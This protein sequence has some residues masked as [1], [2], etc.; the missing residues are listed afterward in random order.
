M[1]I[2]VVAIACVAI[3]AAFWLWWRRRTRGRRYPIV[4][5]HGLFGFD[6]VEVMGRTHHYFNGVVTALEELGEEVHVV[7]L[8]PVASVA[9]RAN[10]L[11]EFVRGL[12]A[13]R[14]NLI[15]HSM[16]GV[17]ARY[18]LAKL[19][20]DDNVASLVTIGTP[21]RGTP[22]ATV[23]NWRPAKA[24]RGVLERLGVSAS[25][26]EWLTPEQM[27]T[28]NEDV[29]D[30]RGVHYAS[31]IGRPQNT[32]LPLSTSRLVMDRRAGTSDGVVPC[33]SQEWGEVILEVDADHWAQIGWTLGGAS[34]DA[35]P[36]YRT[37]VEHLR[38]RGL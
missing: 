13:S 23:G 33:A 20:L 19:G 8:P 18:A 11:S 22:L 6:R 4:L 38:A 10:V 28:F 7:R 36:I 35:S 2:A 3:L 37:I 34:Y 32:S 12:D 1:T 31:V 26:T 21:H 16:G 5:V 9:E 17:D 30:V 25:A 15:A 14:V 29:P 27:A 24:V